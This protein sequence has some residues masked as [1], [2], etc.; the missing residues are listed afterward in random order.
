MTHECRLMDIDHL[1]PGETGQRDV[2]SCEVGMKLAAG[3]QG[4]F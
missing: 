3:G 4:K 2:R 1:D